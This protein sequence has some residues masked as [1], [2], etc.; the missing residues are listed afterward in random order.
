[1]ISASPLLLLAVLASGAGTA[2]REPA[3][4]AAPVVVLE[5]CTEAGCHDEFAKRKVVHEPVSGEMC[6]ACHLEK[7]PGSHEFEYAAEGGELC[8]TCHG[9]FE[10]K[11]VH[12][13]VQEGMCTSCHDPHGSAA[14]NLLLQES[15]ATLCAECHGDPTEGLA[16]AHGPVAAQACTACHAPHASEHPR[17]AV[18]E[19]A[20]LCARCHED[21]SQ[22]LAARKHVHAPVEDD[23]LSCHS[24]HGA[25]NP[26]MLLKPSPALCLD[27]HTDVVETATAY[28]HPPVASDKDCTV[29]HEPH[30]TDVEKLLPDEPMHVCLG[31]HGGDAAKA[32]NRLD[33]RKFLDEHPEHHGPILDGDCTSCHNGHG[34]PYPKLLDAAYPE[35]FYAPYSEDRYALCFQCHDAAAF[36]SERTESDTGFRDGDRNLHFLH[37]NRNPKGRSCRACHDPHATRGPKHVRESVPFG[38]WEI[39]IRFRATETGGSCAPGCHRPYRYDRTLP[40]TGDRP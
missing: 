40:V 31:C 26:W 16:F 28:P 20:T 37:V 2:P 36:A 18:E 27:C 4:P 7:E 29:C 21:I 24:A 32:A 22:A 13:P 25:D 33:L 3:L 35:S 38:S 6:D 9:A 14:E 39:P 19:G 10:G 15:L 34:G 8:A 12:A 30:A 5:G 23:C 11:S 17:L 1:M